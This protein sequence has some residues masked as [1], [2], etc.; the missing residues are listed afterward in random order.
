M[1]GFPSLPDDRSHPPSF[2]PN[3]PVRDL[4]SS[5]LRPEAGGPAAYPTQGRPKKKLQKAGFVMN[6]PHLVMSPGEPLRVEHRRLKQSV[7]ERNIWFIC[8]L[9]GSGA[10]QLH[11]RCSDGRASFTGAKTARARPS[12]LGPPEHSSSFGLQAFAYT[13]PAIWD[14]F[15][16]CLPPI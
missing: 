4:P 3:P 11:F 12:V 8:A 14:V 9:S 15:P 2:T 10:S 5:R 13:V 1:D 6:F 16:T 7:L